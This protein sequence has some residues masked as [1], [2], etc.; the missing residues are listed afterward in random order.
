MSTLSHPSHRHD[1]FIV[2]IPGVTWVGRPAAVFLKLSDHFVWIMSNLLLHE[3]TNSVER[4]LVDTPK[5]LRNGQR[6]GSVG[7]AVASYPTG[8]RF[9]SSHR[10]IFTWNFCL[11]IP[12]CI[13]K[14]RMNQKRSGMKKRRWIKKISSNKTWHDFS[15]ISPMS[16]GA[17]WKKALW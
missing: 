8:P 16:V 15:F 6:C 10:Q 4:W 1:I 13:E 2:S 17:L 9:G 3:H 7:R 11:P 14:T 12:N 5:K